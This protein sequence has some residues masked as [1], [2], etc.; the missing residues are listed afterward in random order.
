MCGIYGAK[1]FDDFKYLQNLNRK[2][3]VFSTGV[4]F[5]TENY[6]DYIKTDGNLSEI[7]WERIK[8][9][10]STNFL[11]HNQ[12]PTST[13][14]IWSRKT[15][16]P[17]VNGAWVVAHNGVL[18][19]FEELCSIYLK[20]HTNP[21]DS[22]IIPALLN[23]FELDNTFCNNIQDETA[24][25]SRVVSL[26]RGTFAVWILNLRQKNVFLARQGSTLYYKDDKFSS[27]MLN[28]Y[29]EV[30]EGVIY[31]YNQNK[32]EKVGKFSYNSPFLIL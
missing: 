19:N 17:F 18:T 3:G 32:I 22:S 1:C 8:S 15:S 14:R 4:C 29:E 21:V 30:E 6:Y 16:H 7:Q 26:L 28:G 31:T 10:N 5:F 12:A 23:K 27:I 9:S 2:R 11:G 13:E 25:I 24:L 20:D